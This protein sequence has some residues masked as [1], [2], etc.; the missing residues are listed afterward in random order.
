MFCGENEK[1]TQS[2]TEETQSFTERRMKGRKGE[3]EKRRGNPC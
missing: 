3:W 1:L 2:Y